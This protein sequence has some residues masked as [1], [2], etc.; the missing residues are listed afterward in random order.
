M[1][2]ATF[3]IIPVVTLL[4]F[5]IVVVAVVRR[6]QRTVPALATR[7]RFVQR[8]MQSRSSAPGIPHG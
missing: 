4:G 8:L 6:H 5:L 7:A 3:P 1:P 2:W